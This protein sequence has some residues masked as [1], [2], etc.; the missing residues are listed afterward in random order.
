MAWKAITA[1]KPELSS[2]C[3]ET[4]SSSGW[5]LRLERVRAGLREPVAYVGDGD[6]LGQVRYPVE[7]QLRALRSLHGL[8]VLGGAVVWVDGDVGLDGKARHRRVAARA[9]ARA[10][11]RSST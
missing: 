3:G 5:V 7:D 6:A 9:G 2:V 4:T 1:P 8:L 10:I 11:F